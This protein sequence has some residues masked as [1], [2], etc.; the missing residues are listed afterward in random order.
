MTGAGKKGNIDGQ[1]V[2]LQQRSRHYWNQ[3]FGVML[4]TCRVEVQLHMGGEEGRAE[5]G[6]RNRGI[7]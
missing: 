7:A 1:T 2:D 5:C 3:Q 6:D 4:H